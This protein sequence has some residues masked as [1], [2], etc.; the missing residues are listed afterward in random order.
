MIP[1]ERIR[2]GRYGELVCIH[3][4]RSECSSRCSKSQHSNCNGK[5]L[6]SRCE[7]GIC[8]CDCHDIKQFLELRFV[9]Y[10]RSDFVLEI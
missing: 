3:R 9:I 2:K 6:K 10:G 4:D 8:K 7:D 5:V 1:D